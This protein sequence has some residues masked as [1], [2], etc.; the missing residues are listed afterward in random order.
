MAF[1]V[2]MNVRAPHRYLRMGGL[3]WLYNT[4]NG[5]GN[6]RFMVVGMSRGGRRVET[7]IDARDVHNLRAGWID[8]RGLLGKWRYPFDTREEAQAWADAIN[9]AYCSGPVREHAA[10]FGRQAD[11][12][13]AG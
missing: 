5:W 10:G 7:W 11:S 3:C 1:G 6:E 9:A 8:D 2:K 12:E 4:N 13:E